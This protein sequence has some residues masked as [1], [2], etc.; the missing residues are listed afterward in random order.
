MPLT[1]EQKYK[2]LRRGV[3]RIIP[4]D[5]FVERLEEGTPLRLKMGFDPSA[6]DIHLGHAV[7]L[8]KLRQLQD[9]GHK[10]VIIVGDWTA[11]IGD[12]SG[13]SATRP[14]LTHAQ[15]VEN[16]ETYL[17]QFFKIVDRDR[18]EVRW[19]SDWFGPFSLADV[20]RLTSKFTVAQFLHR[21]EFATRFQANQ[22]IAITELLYPLLQAYDSVVIESDVEFGGTD[23]MFNLLVGRDLQEMEG[24]RPQ[25]CFLMPLLP[26]TDGVQKMSK[27]LGNYIGIDEPPR[28]IFGKTMSLPDTMIAPYFEN[29]T[30]VSEVDLA[31]I[32]S[33][34]T[35]GTVN[36]MELKKRLASELVGQFHGADAARAAQAFFERTVQRREEPRDMETYKFK[37]VEYPGQHLPDG[38]LVS[39]VT[40]DGKCCSERFREDQ[41]LSDLILKLTPDVSLPEGADPTS[42]VPTS[43]SSGAVRRLINQGGVRIDGEPIRENINLRRL[44]TEKILPAGDEGVVL[45]VG[46]RRYLRLQI[47]SS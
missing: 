5:E 38:L 26:G 47:D 46:R 40:K 23:Q 8:R 19:Q 37:P 25:Q 24:Q 41:P 39:W 20:I 2:I 45:R 1:E 31:E 43:P 14:M 9:L 30:D 3:A 34:I 10:V 15:V 18:A 33:A 13:R 6:P 21:D 16:A 4:E 44:V 12:P 7:G 11:Q 27:S 42:L 29:L 35:S 32:N 17:A 36:P 28:E 22:P